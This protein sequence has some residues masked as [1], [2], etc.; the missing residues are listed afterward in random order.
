MRKLTK[1]K[2][3]KRCIGSVWI[4]EIAS[5]KTVNPRLRIMKTKINCLSLLLVFSFILIKMPYTFD[6]TVAEINTGSND[7]TERDLNQ[8]MR[9]VSNNYQND[10][11]SE[12]YVSEGEFVEKARCGGK[13]CLFTE[14]EVY[15]RSY[16]Y[17][18]VVKVANF[19]LIPR[20]IYKSDRTDKW[21]A[22]MDGY[23]STFPDYK[24]FSDTPPGTSALLTG[25]RFFE[26]NGPL[27][28]PRRYRFS[29]SAEEQQ[30]DDS[31][32]LSID[33]VTDF[34]RGSTYKGRMLIRTEDE[35]VQRIILDRVPFH[36]VNF[37]RWHNNAQSEITFG[38]WNERAYL[39]EIMTR[40]DHREVDYM[41]AARFG[42]PELYGWETT[43]REFFQIQNHS[44]NPW[45]P[46]IVFLNRFESRFIADLSAIRADLEHGKTLEQQF[47]D[48]SNQPW[49]YNLKHNDEIHFGHAGESD[50]EYAR[51]VTEEIRKILE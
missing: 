7:L 49:R 14:G 22:S 28:H 39:S 13:W 50:F 51:T 24:Y 11:L 12:Q 34:S 1:E 25:F 41:V 2:K 4:F 45:L 20:V 16:G 37:H 36:S 26:M 27:T 21:K 9:S 33:F 19:I 46:E 43:D 32:L 6:P 10:I 48:N 35:R 44:T 42:K 5:N 17:D 30:P 38:Y 31:G 47:V 29:V 3:P 40:L 8:L 15:L 23:E 18:A